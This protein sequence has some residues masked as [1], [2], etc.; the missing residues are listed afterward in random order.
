MLPEGA[1]RIDANDS[2]VYE[3]CPAVRVLG[4]RDEAATIRTNSRIALRP[5]NKGWTNANYSITP[6]TNP[7]D[8]TSIRLIAKEARLVLLFVGNHRN[9]CLCRA[10]G[11]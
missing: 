5:P 7:L 10:G 6:E 8:E 9:K 11:Q 3:R 2:R 4:K 1:V